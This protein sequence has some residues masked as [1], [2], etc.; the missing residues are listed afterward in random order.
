MYNSIEQRWGG[1]REGYLKLWPVGGLALFRLRGVAYL[2]QKYKV[3]L[4]GAWKVEV[5]PQFTVQSAWS[6]VINLLGLWR[7]TPTETDAIKHL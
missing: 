1:S 6:S 7:K 2:I 3:I 5:R 4:R